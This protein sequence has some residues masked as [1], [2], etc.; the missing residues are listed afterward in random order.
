MGTTREICK[1]LFT[2]PDQWFFCLFLLTF[3]LSVRKVLFFYPFPHNFNENTG[4][5]LYI[6]DIFL[7][8][9][10]ITWIFFLLRNKFYI[11][12]SN[13]IPI[14]KPSIFKS[15]YFT[16]PLGIITI[17]FF[18]IL[19]SENK[20]IA[21]YR[22]IKFL[23]FYF[24]YVY[25]IYNLFK[26]NASKIFLNNVFKIIIIAAILH[27]IIA[28]IQFFTQH[29][30]G[31]FWLK[32]S[33]ISPEITGVAKLIFNGSKYIRAYGLFPHP[34]ILG[35]FLLFSIVLTWYYRKLFH[36]CPPNGRVKQFTPLPNPSLGR[37]GSLKCS[38]WN[39][40]CFFL[41]L[42]SMGSRIKIVPRGTIFK[43]ILAIQILALFL[44]FSKSAILGLFVSIIYISIKIVPRGTFQSEGR[45]PG[46]PLR[47]V[48]KLFHVEQFSKI[49]LPCPAKREEGWGEGDGKQ[50]VPRG[51]LFILPALL[52]FI[53]PLTL[54]LLKPDSNSLFINSLRERWFYLG[55]SSGIIV[56]NLLLGVGSGQFVLN[57]P[58][59]INQQIIP[60]WQFQPVHNVFLIIW[61]ELG[62]VGLGLF[63]AFIL[64]LF[65]VEQFNLPPLS[66]R[67]VEWGGKL[68]TS[69]NKTC[70]G[71]GWQKTNN[72]PRGTLF[73]LSL[74]C[75]AKREKG[76]G[77][78]KIVPR[79]TILPPQ[80]KYIQLNTLFKA[81]L[82]G[83]L[84]IML[85]DHYLWDIHQ[86]QVILWITLGLVVGTQQKIEKEPVR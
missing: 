14:L 72:V 65:H 68:A 28:I 60:D 31:L 63:I 53:M 84:F 55:V 80:Y 4:A 17:S 36:A 30:I 47:N 85:F 61:S 39:I 16:I 6:S 5:Y 2:Q 32:E 10:I 22:S 73:N 67:E 58:H 48:L 69:T 59:Y 27:S 49:P 46:S 40:Y 79:G 34:N 82:L 38:T 78:G 62:L 70:Q 74:P 86:G 83:Y 23:E 41:T 54:L 29:S 15:W 66:R 35:G 71:E 45:P 50:N 9:T 20:I 7:L 57:I 3:T 19:W 56:D 37:G 26:N 64:K 24:L 25:I 13:I 43:I 12:S 1:K 81:I 42:Y 18:S 76:L 51:T 52:I 77:G 33:L 8:L 75:L 11:L 21:L 44:T